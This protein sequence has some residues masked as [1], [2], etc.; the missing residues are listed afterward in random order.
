MNWRSLLNREMRQIFITDPRRAIFILGASLAYLVLFS[1]LY[2]TS[3]V[4]SVPLVI[5]DEDQTQFSR[6]MIQALN[7][8]ERFQ[9]VNYA[10]SQDEME[11]ALHEK[12]AYAA[13]HIP[14]K[15]ARDAKLGHSASVLL[16]VNGSNIIITNTVTNAAQE[17]IS[18]FSQATAANILE[19]KSAQMPYLAANKA[20][21]ID[22]RLRVLNNPTQSYLSFFVIGLAMAALQQGI[23]L[24]VGAS[25]RSVDHLAELKDSNPLLVIFTKLLSYYVLAFIAFL[26]TLLVAVKL[27]GLPCRAPLY[28]LFLLAAA[29]ILA[30]IGFSAFLASLCRTELT[31]TRISIAY[32]V[33]AFVLSGYTWPQE[34][35]DAFTQLLSY[36]FPLTYVS[37]SVRELMIA[38]SSPVLYR[39]AFVLFAAGAI[40]TGLAMRYYIQRLKG[41]NVKITEN[42]NGA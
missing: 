13:I 42:P 8:S 28:Q 22:L 33:P 40:L 20:G 25:I 10:L 2:S 4:N 27:V 36:F 18:A 31:F 24:A 39:N 17:V 30:A 12:K 3:S 37:N 6:L 21:A 16:M 23:F 32:T 7:D 29:F 38:G 1:I 14:F 41:I 35:M 34:A 19:A 5:Y 26:V 9:I 11:H 15:F